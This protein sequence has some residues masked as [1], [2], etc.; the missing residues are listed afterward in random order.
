M[1]CDAD[2]WPRWTFSYPGTRRRYRSI[3]SRGGWVLAALFSTSR[4][5]PGKSKCSR[6]ARTSNISASDRGE[7]FGSARAGQRVLRGTAAH[8]KR[9][10]ENA[11]AGEDLL[12]GGEERTDRRV[13]AEQVGVGE[14]GRGQR[15]GR[16]PGG[17]RGPVRLPRDVGVDLGEAVAVEPQRAAEQRLGDPRGQLVEAAGEFLVVVR[18]GLAQQVAQQPGVQEGH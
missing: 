2:D 7:E 4:P 3:S 5:V 16:G 12:A 6:M 9:A 1:R 17:V 8:R 13:L 11:G 10:V 15:L 14:R 18:V